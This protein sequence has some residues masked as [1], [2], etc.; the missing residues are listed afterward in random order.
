VNEDKIILI[1]FLIMLSF[2]ILML[3][4]GT[5][6]CKARGEL[7]YTNMTTLKEWCDMMN[8]GDNWAYGHV[9]NLSRY[10]NN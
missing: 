9:E 10:C 8:Y 7:N 1:I 5:D 2:I 3:V 6:C 4:T